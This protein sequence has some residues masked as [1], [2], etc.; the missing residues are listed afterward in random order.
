MTTV[1][2]VVRQSDGGGLAVKVK[3]TKASVWQYFGFKPSANMEHD[4]MSE[5]KGVGYFVE[6]LV[7][8]GLSPSA[9]HQTT[10]SCLKVTQTE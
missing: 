8:C 9:P 5:E 10:P 1:K 3:K 2:T 7:A 4:N 6:K